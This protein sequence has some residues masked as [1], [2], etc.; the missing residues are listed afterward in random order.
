MA[1]CGICESA[2]AEYVHK[3][4]ARY[5]KC[6]SCGFV[7][8]NPMPTS[9]ELSRLYDQG[10][11]QHTPGTYSKA[12]SRA[13]RAYIRALQLRRYFRGRDALD[14]GSGGGFI[15]NAM[16]AFGAKSASGLDIDKVAVDY[17][18]SHYPK[19]QFHL[20]TYEE[21]ATRGMTFDFIYSSEVI[22]H[23]GDIDGMMSFFQTVTKPGASVFIT[24]PDIGHEAVPE[25]V[26]EW[27]VLAPPHH[28]QFFTDDSVR[29]LFGN[30]GFK[31]VKRFYKRSAPTLKFIA[32]KTA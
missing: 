21:F 32:Q 27:P 15:V 18:Q 20:N 6:T 28:V 12:G 10:G 9:A 22:E 1:P 14:F 30:Y 16:R 13:R 25:Q 7:F 5:D 19:C 2:T 4:G 26:T 24:T 8:M 31:I 11:P 23:I 29:Q 3:A 17:A